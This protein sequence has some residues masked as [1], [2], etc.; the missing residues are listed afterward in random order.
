MY[1]G[2][3]TKFLSRQNEQC[4]LRILQNVQS[5]L[6]WLI[7]DLFTLFGY[8]SFLVAETKS[9]PHRVNVP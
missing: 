9:R 4:I 8:I 3:Q 5:Y 7:E 2:L 1:M 6:L